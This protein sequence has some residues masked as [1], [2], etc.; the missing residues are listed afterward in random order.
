MA[1]AFI[2]VAIPFDSIYVDRVEEYLKRLGNPP[3]D[4]IKS[5]LD[6]GKFV[7]FM[8]MS[9][10]REDGDRDRPSHLIIEI[11]A[12]GTV[13]ST[14]EQLAID[15]KPQL[16]GVLR[17]AGVPNPGS[18]PLSRVLES[19]HIEVGQDWSGPLGVNFDGTP[20]MT[21]TQILQERDLAK[22][23]AGMLDDTHERS[24]LETLD[25][26]RTRLWSDKN[27]KW[28][29]IPA[30]TTLLKGKPPVPPE[31]SIGSILFNVGGPLRS[32]VI[33]FF[34]PLN[35]VALF[36]SIFIGLFRGFGAAYWTFI[37]LLLGLPFVSIQSFWKAFLFDLGASIVVGLFYGFGAAFWWFAGLLIGLPILAI[38][39]VYLLLRGAEM[40]DVPEDIEPSRESVAQFMKRE[41]W[42]AQSHLFNATTVKPGWLRHLTLRVGLWLAGIFAA[43]LS[44]PGYLTEIGVIHF[45]RWFVLPGTDKLIFLSNYDGAWQTYLEDFIVRTP[46]GVTMIWSN[47]KGFPRTKNLTTGGARDGDRL[48]RFIRRGQH[49]T[50]FWYSAYPDL[51]LTRIRANA[52]I[53]NDISQAKS[54]EEAQAWLSIFGA[55]PTP[56][57]VPEVVLFGRKREWFTLPFTA[58]PVAARGLPQDYISALA[59]RDLKYLEH[60]MALFFRF[61]EPELARQWLANVKS[62]IGYG[63]VSRAGEPVAV[64]GF[65]HS[66]LSKL[67]IESKD[68]KTFPV[69]FQDG[70]SAATRSAVLGDTDHQAPGTWAWGGPKTDVDGVM[71][72]YAGDKRTRVDFAE[73]QYRQ[74]VASGL[75][76]V[77][78]LM[79][80]P[81]LNVE[82][83]GFADGI[84]QPVIRGIA[85]G[86]PEHIVEP[87]EF[88]L[89]HP[90][91]A[92]Y[93]PPSPSVAKAAD[94]NDMLHPVK[95]DPDP[96]RAMGIKPPPNGRRD[97]GRNGT[98]LV[99]R[100]LEQD[101]D[102]FDDFLDHAAETL[103]GNPRLPE[104]SGPELAQWLGG[105]MVGRW[106][107]GTPLVRNPEGPGEGRDDNR[108]LFDEREQDRGGAKCPLGAHVRRSNPRKSLDPDEQ[109][110]LEVS[111]RHR[112]LRVGRPYREPDG[113]GRGLLFMCLNSD[114]ERQ[115]E[116]IQ[117]NW[118]LGKSFHSLQHEGDPMLS[119]SP[120]DSVFTIP[121]NSGPVRL[122]CTGSFLRDRGLTGFITV[123]GSGYFFVPGRD[124]FNY[125][126]ALGQPTA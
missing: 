109:T 101:R 97:L 37:V 73:Y 11:S 45:A 75:E 120:K 10:L 68:L 33:N 59:F 54:A 24:A 113:A 49:P 27:W 41:A 78:V 34:W 8:S 121:T 108:F 58:K 123:K 110:E 100:Q 13:R 99:I 5:A 107:N 60:G 119:A 2:T 51:T 85:N 14:L 17:H 4:E 21:V 12:D 114:I 117:Q 112:I 23:I 76:M 64:V 28:A 70:P 87:G 15:L 18:A 3:S 65:S 19:Y 47:T 86:D 79:L 104:L 67:G 81:P 71:L 57:Q 98:Y 106:K 91:N 1:H 26:I 7:H 30:P 118:I 38:V 25:R 63:N 42:G 31:W 40:R 43:Y 94:P 20:D 89:G 80:D 9:V 122:K 125:L 126:A 115:F 103:A 6:A 32:A 124:E 39:V 77:H 105:K 82:R 72:L 16:D 61:T 56:K 22:E 92:G 44:R 46:R 93:F 88:I 55:P 48:K 29:F 90:N 111:N 74:A 50:W 52:A 116:F 95:A 69:A 66:G 84:S 96:A 35:I 62:D 83:F 53:R 36:A 102:A